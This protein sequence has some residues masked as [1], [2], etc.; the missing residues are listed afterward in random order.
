MLIM[1]Y[2]LAV[3][4]LL[5]VRLV[6]AASDLSVP[7]PAKS[8][9]APKANATQ[10]G[11]S[12]EP[13]KR[14]TTALPAIIEISQSSAVQAE[15]TDKTEKP[16]DYSSSEWWLVYL[17][18][19]LALITCALAI[20]TAMLWKATVDLGR[21]ARETSARQASEMQDSLK[22]SRDSIKAI[23]AL[24]RA[25][26]YAFPSG[27]FIDSGGKHFVGISLCIEN[28]G[29][30]PARLEFANYDFFP[31]KE[32]QFSVPSFLSST[33]ELRQIIPPNAEPPFHSSIRFAMGT[34]TTIFCGHLHFV[35]VFGNRWH[36]TW[37]YRLEPSERWAAYPIEYNAK[38]KEGYDGFI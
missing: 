7:V 18:G 17:T 14:G 35:D 38:E 1:R 21:D 30:T 19:A 31:Y 12:T 36:T 20:Y 34:Q 15:T 2:L 13:D 10:H 29:K 6:G 11:K 23:Q 4:L 26:V 25:H 3:A 5:A 16:H 9:G 28:Y 27:P 22:A 37:A 24:E 33:I 8:A 32:G